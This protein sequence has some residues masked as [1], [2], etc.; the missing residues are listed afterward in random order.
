MVAKT[1]A[2]YGGGLKLLR[3][4]TLCTVRIQTEGRIPAHVDP[5]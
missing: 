1:N 2:G 3:F 5:N 4:E